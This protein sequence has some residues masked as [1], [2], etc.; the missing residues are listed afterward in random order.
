MLNSLTGKS[1]F[2][3]TREREAAFN[4]LKFLLSSSNVILQFPDMRK[5]FELSTDASDSSVGYVL[6]QRDE[7]GR[8]RPVF[9]ASK[10]LRESELSWHTRDK[11][12]FAFVFAL[13]KFRYYL[14]GNRFIWH[15]DHEGLRWLTQR[16]K[17]HPNPGSAVKSLRQKRSGAALNADGAELKLRLIGF[18]LSKLGIMSVN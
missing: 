3:L 9:F 8:D 4:D 11:E 16:R 10:A 13:R 1:K 12:T 7:L 14:L 18:P 2:V 17:G 5:P 15:T 6:S